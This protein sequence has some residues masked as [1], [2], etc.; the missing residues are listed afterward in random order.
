MNRLSSVA[1]AL[2]AALVV[3]VLNV[4]ASVNP[5][6]CRQTKNESLVGICFT[7]PPVGGSCS[8][9]IGGQQVYLAVNQTIQAQEVF[10][11]TIMATLRQNRG[12]VDDNCLVVGDAFAC[13]TVYPSCTRTVP[14]NPFSEGIPA[15]PCE[16]FCQSLWSACNV[17]F[18]QFNLGTILGTKTFDVQD[19]SFPHCP[20]T[21]AGVGTFEQGGQPADIF[22]VRFIRALGAF[23]IGYKGQPRNPPTA[24][25]GSATAGWLYHAASGNVFLNDG[26]WLNR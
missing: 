1:A 10:A 16:S 20:S 7:Y 2:V 12:L 25:T 22:G 26:N 14:S 18:N 9:V 4:E 13:N 24:A 5:G 15:L 21:V 19:F 17:P 3:L 11:L 6:L 23:P 8:S